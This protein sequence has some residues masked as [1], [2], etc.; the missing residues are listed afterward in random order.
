[1]SVCMATHFSPKT[2]Q[3]A[4]TKLSGKSTLKITGKDKVNFGPYQ[5][6]ITPKLR[7]THMKNS[8]PNMVYCSYN[9]TG[10]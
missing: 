1:M 5:C 10:L 8:L 9:E 2:T 6:N 7:E 4:A 3:S